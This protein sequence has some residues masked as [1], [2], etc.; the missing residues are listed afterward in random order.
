MV[1]W[2][3][4]RI[5]HRPERRSPRLRGRQLQEA[6]EGYAL[7]SPWLVGFLVFTLGP[8]IAA[9]YFSLTDYSVFSAPRWIGLENYR[10]MLGDRL[11]SVSLYNTVYYTALS[12]PL[13]LAGSLLIAVLLRQDFRG[14]RWFRTFFYFPSVTS[15]VAAA[16]LWAMVLDPNLGLLNQALALVGIKG[17]GW[18]TDPSWSKPSLVLM[19]L[20]YIGGGQAVIFLAGLKG[21]PSV[22]YEAAEIDGAGQW[23]LFR[24]VT[25]PMITP[26][27]FFN[28]IM[29]VIGSFQVFTNA[30]VMT[31]GG[32]L[33]STYF[34]VLWLYEKA[35]LNADYGFACAAAYVLFAIVLVLTLIQFRMAN[36]WV[37]YETSPTSARR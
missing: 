12:V 13:S 4:K 10:E 8:F 17:P 36:R 16:M 32:P 21:I 29:G 35:F 15:G 3:Q 2:V 19:D 11:F 28:L 37:Y 31:Q 25:L 7:A 9:L 22:L 30:Y 20:W 33:N 14:I 26:S 24:H 1:T 6:I 5:I 23:G 34:Y 18:I 27:I